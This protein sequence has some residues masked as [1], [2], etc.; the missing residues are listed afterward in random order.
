MHTLTSG[1]THVSRMLYKLSGLLLLLLD[2]ALI[3]GQLAE[4][5]LDTGDVNDTDQ[6]DLHHYAKCNETLFMY[7]LQTFCMETFDE[8]MSNLGQ[9]N[10]CDWE[11]V[12]SNYN[13]LTHCMEICAL[14]LHCY[15]PNTV[16]QKLFV[17]VHKQYF[18]LCGTKEDT[19]P[20]APARVVLVL[21]L[22]PVSVIPILVY[23]VIWKS[24]VID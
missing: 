24:S 12:L 4:D 20:D 13:D 19:L 6:E 22:L 9:E 8:Q 7:S 11:M 1:H 10:W 3:S 16:V 18:S 5:T 21:T 2:L 15:Y 17:E 14:H 23:M